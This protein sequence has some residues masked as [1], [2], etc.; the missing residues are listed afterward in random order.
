MEETAAFTRYLIRYPSDGL[1]IYGFMDVPKGDGPFPVVIALH[2]L[3]LPEDYETLDYTTTLAD[4]FAQ[5]G[6]LVLH[7]NM[8]GY[9]PSDNG[10]NLFQVGVAVDVLNLI[11]LVKEQGGRAGALEQ[12]DS[13]L[14]GLWGH[15][16]GGGVVLRVLTVSSDVKAAILYASTSGDE[17]RNSKLYYALTN[18]EIHQA[19]LQVDQESLQRISPQNYYS[20]ISAAVKLYHGSDDEVIPVRWAVD[21][22]DALKMALVNVDCVYYIGGKHTFFSRFQPEFNN[23]MLTFYQ[24]YLIP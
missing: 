2:G 16:L 12:A 6:Y 10:D 8:R 14:I 24:T 19:E 23:S 7:P 20:N 13:A 9:P 3:V 17:T 22:C 21:T 18:D 15:S 5:N 11:A 4:M 1:T